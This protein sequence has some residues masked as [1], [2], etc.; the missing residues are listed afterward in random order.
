MQAFFQVVI[1]HVTLL[2]CHAELAH[3]AMMHANMAKK[4]KLTLDGATG[5]VVLATCGKASI[6]GFLDSNVFCCPALSMLSHLEPI[7]KD[8]TKTAGHQSPGVPIRKTT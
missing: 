1:M 6:K 5:D 4:R 2:K 8:A 3:I 7:V